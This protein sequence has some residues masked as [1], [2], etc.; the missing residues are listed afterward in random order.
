MKCN[1]F[2]PMHYAFYAFDQAKEKYL[3]VVDIEI[4]FL[5][6]SFMSRRPY[7]AEIWPI[8]RKT[9]SNQSINL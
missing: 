2:M 7:M 9:L 3:H 4:L 8:R 6:A 1:A 5:V